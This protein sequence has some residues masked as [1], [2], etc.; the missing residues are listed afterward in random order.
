MNYIRINTADNVAV[1]IEPLSKGEKIKVG[2]T[3]LVL[4]DDIPA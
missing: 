1:A 4:K 3:Q 2:T